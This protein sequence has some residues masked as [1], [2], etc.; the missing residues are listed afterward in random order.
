MN[1]K[2]L[3]TTSGTGSRLGELTKNTNKALLKISG[4]ET[5]RYIIDAYPKDIPIVITLGFLGDQVRDF[6]LATYPDR[7]FE[8][9]T[10]DHVSLV[11]S[12]YRAKDYL[13][14]PFVF[15]ACDTLVTEPIPEPDR[16]WTAGY[17]TEA[18]IKEGMSL[19]Q[20][21]THKVADGKIIK[22][23]DKGE[24]GFQSIHIGLDGIHDYQEFWRTLED[25]YTKDTDNTS[26]S[27][28]HILSRMFEQGTSFE[29]IPYNVWLDTGNLDALEKTEKCLD[30]VKKTLPRAVF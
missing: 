13:Q 26:L 7:K 2:L 29:W 10:D 21:R 3:I 19:D 11:D 30:G 25:I 8:F 4:K 1:Y 9:S 18:A 5:I 17:L 23:L 14:C 16:N 15:H 22:L 12:M 6:L 28:V 27:D 24:S 20:Y